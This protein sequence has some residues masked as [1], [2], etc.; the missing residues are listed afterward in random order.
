MTL[1]TVVAY[2]GV[3]HCRAFATLSI[4]Y[5]AL[6][7]ILF[8][9][10]V[11]V[12]TVILMMMTKMMMIIIITMMVMMIMI[13]MIIITIK[14]TKTILRTFITMRNVWK[15]PSRLFQS[16]SVY[17]MCGTPTKQPSRSK[18]VTHSMPQGCKS[19]GI[20]RHSGTVHT[21]FGQLPAWGQYGLDI[22]RHALAICCI[23]SHFDFLVR[24]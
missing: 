21:D 17:A 24:V 13:M 4:L 9:A 1:P 15:T 6:D 12:V 19:A 23:F 14:T 10:K 5:G 8:I 2:C 7:S 18:G 3:I 20:C 11:V 16:Q 22:V